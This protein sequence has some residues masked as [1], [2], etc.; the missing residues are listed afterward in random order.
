MTAW[1]DQRRAM[2][3]DVHALMGVPAL[4]IHAPG[5]TPLPL[6]IRGPHNKRPVSTGSKPGDPG[7]AERED[8]QPRL[9]VM[10]ADLVTE[11][12]PQG[13]TMRNGAIF[14]VEPG[15]AYRVNRTHPRD[16]ISI[17]VEVDPMVDDETADLPLPG[18]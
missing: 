7:W 14:S 9:I 6:T 3:G 8:I 1:R 2:R 15:E 13:L 18:A 17:T 16:D 4:Y 5:A 10:R 12:F 11:E